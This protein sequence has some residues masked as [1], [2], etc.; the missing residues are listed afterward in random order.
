V[1][2]TA[3]NLAAEVAAHEWYHTLELAPGVVTPGW[4]DTRGVVG[5]LPFPASL[6]G[7]RCLDVGTFDG[8]WA[9]EM[10]RRGADEVLAIDVLDP[11]HWDWP[12]GSDE[13]TIRVM[14]R[15]KASGSGFELAAER[16]GSKVV[17]RELSVLDLDPAEVGQFDLI[18]LGSLLI[19]MRDPVLALEKVRSVCRGSLIVVDG[20]DPLLSLLFRRLPIAQLDGRGRPWWWYPN[21]AGLARMV[22]AAGFE[23]E[24]GPRRVYIPPGA[25]RKLSRR[26]RPGLL[27]SAEGRMNLTVA[28]RGDPHAAFLC[29]PRS[30]IS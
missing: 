9:F 7:A 18:Y 25:G 14:D 23:I 17:R 21:A 6:E 8:F 15:R 2:A 5:R 22:Q 10:E 13:E 24:D 16:L 12:A 29:K 3:A 19:H 4:L 11:R 1:E 20:I 28:W 30:G 27:R 26:I